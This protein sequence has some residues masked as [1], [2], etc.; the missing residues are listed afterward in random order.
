[1]ARPASH[2][3]VH[4]VGG[5]R[6]AVAR[7][8][9]PSTRPAP[10]G[11]ICDVMDGH[12]VPNITFG[13]PVIKAVRGASQEDLRRASDDRAGRSVSRRV[14]RCRR[15]HHHRARRSRS[16]S[17]P[18]AAGDQGARQEG[19]RVASIPGT[20]ESVIEYVLD[21]L[22]LILLMTVNPGFGGQAFISAVV[23]KI[24]RVKALVGDRPDRH[25]GRR[26][27]D[28]RDRAARCRCGGQCARG[29]FR[30]LQGRHARRLR[31][32]YRRDPQRRD[33]NQT[34]SSS[35]L[36]YSASVFLK[37]LPSFMMTLKFLPGSATRE[38]S[39][40]GLPSTRIRSARA[41]CS[42]MPNVPG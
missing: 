17:R 10:T 34:Y 26:R 37:T 14:R 40:S 35:D 12:F 3:T 19:R 29:R 39:S 38:R 30:R 21:R 11:S 2:R 28:A 8:S 7:R 24:R 15:R 13:P 9:Q 33:I 6:P 41:P 25:R 1:M 4:P 27:R 32:E 16:A 20:P 23:D 5:L 42:T 18:L 31:Q 22:D 36:S